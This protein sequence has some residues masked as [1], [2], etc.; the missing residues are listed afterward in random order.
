MKFGCYPPLKIVVSHNNKGLVFPLEATGAVFHVIGTAPG[1]QLCAVLLKSLCMQDFCFDVIVDVVVIN[2][3]DL[4]HGLNVPFGI[5]SALHT[6][7]I[8]TDCSGLERLGVQI[9]RWC[10]WWDK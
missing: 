5:I 2:V 4:H 7:G 9:D 3:C 6:C 10:I 8:K 1:I